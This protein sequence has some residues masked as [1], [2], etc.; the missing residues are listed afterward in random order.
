MADD[1][2]SDAPAEFP[3]VP[4]WVITDSCLGYMMKRT[5]FREFNNHYHD[6]AQ[7]AIS[8]EP[9]SEKARELRKRYLSYR[10]FYTSFTS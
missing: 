7:R 6:L 3:T 2:F 9:D 8:A 4:A 10:Q 5:E 1:P